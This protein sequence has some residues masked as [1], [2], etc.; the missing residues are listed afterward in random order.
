MD[1]TGFKEVDFNT[2]QAKLNEG[3]IV[4]ALRIPQDTFLIH[5]PEEDGGET[6]I[7][8]RYKSHR[9]STRDLIEYSEGPHGL[10][11][12]YFYIEEEVILG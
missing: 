3:H 11:R 6:V 1:T 8:S 2:A 12:Y 4:Y 10:P 7:Y 5:I 9:Y